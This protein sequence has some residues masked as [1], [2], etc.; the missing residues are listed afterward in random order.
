MASGHSRASMLLQGKVI[1]WDRKHCGLP[2]NAPFAKLSTAKEKKFNGIQHRDSGNVLTREL[3][4]NSNN[5]RA[6]SIQK[7][8]TR[9]CSWKET[10]SYF[11]HTC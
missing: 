5:I 2:K 11:K 10:A 3:I 7:A 8:M 6:Q 9:N 4:H 1:M